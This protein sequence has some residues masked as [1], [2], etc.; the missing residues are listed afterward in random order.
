MD[1]TPGQIVLKQ[2]ENGEYFYT[3][4]IDK[5]TPAQ[6]G[7]WYS[8]S[9]LEDSDYYPD[10][11]SAG[12]LRAIVQNGYWGTES[13]TGSL[14]EI[15]TLLRNSYA[16]DAEVTVKDKDGKE[17]TYKIAELIDDLKEHE[18][19]ACTQAAIWSYS[20]GAL[21]TMNGVDGVAVV[22]VQSA[23]KCF[24]SGGGALNQYKQAYNLESDARLKALY[25]CLMGLEPVY[26]TNEDVT[27]I[28]NEKNNIEEMTL[29]VH[30]KAE[31]DADGNKIEANYDDDDTNDVY[32]T[33]LNFTLAFVP[34]PETDDLLVYITYM[35]NGEEV[36]VT[37]R[38]AGENSDGE[39]YD[40]VDV[41]D[42]N[43]VYTIK[44]L[45]L[46]EGS[47]QFDLRLEGTQYLKD[48][49]YIYTAHGGREA[50][51][52]LVGMA[53][54]IHNV[55]VTASMTLSFEVDETN[56]VVAER[57]WH[58][59]SDPEIDPE[60]PSEDPKDPT[61]DPKDPTED[62]ED[63]TEEP[64]DPKDPEPKPEEPS[65]KKFSFKLKVEEEP[66]VV[67]IPEE[68]IPLVNIPDE[69]I[70]LT[71]IPD[72]PVP[73]TGD[74]MFWY[75]S[76]AAAVLGLCVLNLFGKKKNHNA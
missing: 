65:K 61:E 39:T 5:E 64:K 34:D 60:D 37:R 14:A 57:E 49:V 33:D 44:G 66:E 10:D 40:M 7:Y 51:Q 11:E 27:T 25:E 19:L 67:E 55:D 3:Y 56:N 52:T 45:Q 22:G 23:E 1:G 53:E 76:S 16:V 15:K 54:G 8:I 32:N 48:G 71:D 42:E 43:G 9:N 74:S 24:N 72:E 75:I 63:P 73:L 17:H 13:D 26:N 47:T 62:P 31:K 35:C 6:A 69:E 18:A 4:C 50:S 20:N 28:I 68:E 58:Y 38:L 29:V 30:D 21:A 36:V 2:G 41:D 70:P 59:E 46:G 12:M